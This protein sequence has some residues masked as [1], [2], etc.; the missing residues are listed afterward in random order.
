VLA[1]E[2]PV[3]G[4]AAVRFKAG[5]PGEVALALFDVLGRRV[6]VV[7]DGPADAT[8]RTVTLDATGLSAGVYVLRLVAGGRVESRTVTVVR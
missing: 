5:V 3:S 2:N 1:V 7:A 6:A 4:K 8:E